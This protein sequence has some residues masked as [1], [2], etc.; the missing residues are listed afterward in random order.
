MAWVNESNI[1]CFDNDHVGSS[2]IYSWN[3]SHPWEWMINGDTNAK[4]NR[5]SNVPINLECIFFDALITGFK[6][7]FRMT[8]QSCVVGFLKKMC[9][10]RCWKSSPMYMHATNNWYAGF[11]DIMIKLTSVA[12]KL[13]SSTWVALQSSLYEKSWVGLITLILEILISLHIYIF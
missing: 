7:N 13:F 4:N 8:Q 11:I 3:H 5:F 2:S 1:H 6:K 10:I 9:H 12:W